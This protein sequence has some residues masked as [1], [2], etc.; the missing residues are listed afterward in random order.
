MFVDEKNKASCKEIHKSLFVVCLDKAL[1]AK[2]E[3]RQVVAAKQCIHGG[4]SKGNVANRWYD[5]TIQ[6][7]AKI[8][9]KII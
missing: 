8:K 5:K 3:R 7:K 2:E 1:P 6:V 9:A 4:G